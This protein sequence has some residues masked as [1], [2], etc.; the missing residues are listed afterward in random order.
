MR[1]TFRGIKPDAHIRIKGAGKHSHGTV[2]RIFD[3]VRES[4]K[5]QLVE[6]RSTY[7]GGLRIAPLEHVHTVRRVRFS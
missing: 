5:V 4:R 1:E 3:T 6:Y 2:V 7:N